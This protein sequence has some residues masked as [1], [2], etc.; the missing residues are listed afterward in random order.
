MKLLPHGTKTAALLILMLAGVTSGILGCGAGQLTATN[1]TD[2]QLSALSGRVHGGP[3]PIVGATVSLYATTSGGYGVGSTALVSALT[4]A[5][6]NFQFSG[7][8]VCPAN[9]FAYVAI[10]GGFTGSNTANPNSILL[11]ALGPCSGVNS[12]TFVWANE[13]TTIAATYALANFINV[14]GDAVNGYTVGIGAP[15]SNNG[16][17]GCYPNAYYSTCASLTGAGLKHAFNNAVGLVSNTNGVANSTMNNGALIPSQEI[18]TLGNILQACVNSNGGGTNSSGAPSAVTSSNGVS[19]DGTPCGK[20]FAFSSYTSNGTLTGTQTAAGNTVD[21][22][23]NLVKH[24]SGTVANFNSTCDS[25]SNTGSTTAASCIFNLSGAFNY[26]LPAMA[27]APPDWMLGVSYPKGSFATSTTDTFTAAGTCGS[28]AN[29]GLFYTTWVSS[30]INDNLVVLNADAST[31]ACAN[32]IAI[33]SDGTILGNSA[34]DTAMPGVVSLAVDAWG[35]AMVPLRAGNGV[36]FFQYAAGGTTDVNDYSIPQVLSV[37]SP[38]TSGTGT[39]SAYKA[40]YAQV[41]SNNRIYVPA[42]NGVNTWG[43]LAP[44]TLSHAAPVYTT[45]TLGST[46]SALSYTSI[47]L[48]NNAFTTKTANLIGTGNAGTSFTSA[49]AS[50]G[51]TAGVLSVDSNGSVW[52]VLNNGSTPGTSKTEVLKFPY[53][54]SGA[55][56]TW[57]TGATLTSPTYAYPINSNSQ[58]NNGLTFQMKAA[59]MDSSN[60]L[61]F[62]DFFGQATTAPAYGGSLRGYDTVNNYGTTQLQGCKFLAQSSYSITAWTISSSSTTFTLANSTPPAV[63]AVMN[64]SGFASSTFFNGQQVTV[65]ATT[66]G[67]GSTTGT[68]TVSATFGQSASSATEAGTATGRVATSCGS[69]TGD[70]SSVTSTPFLLYQTRGIAVDTMG[71]LWVVNGVQ[72]QLNE[73]LG[74]AAPTW[75][76]YVHNG[77]SNKP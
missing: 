7:T 28:A 73:I 40:A 38:V 36:K 39:T 62:P 13:L 55:I 65:T 37:V 57:G 17:A 67:S 14:T 11:T 22:I 42:V 64:L 2:T 66:T 52:Q 12:G 60:V 47:D 41:D 61:W 77:V 63:G 71:N 53:T 34:I 25:N 70:A 56:V 43:Y 4:D 3:N 6:G 49:A 59:V 20:L 46:T 1:A 45:Q 35:H 16:S 18:N 21:A 30:D 31:P 51:S 54:A 32:V 8:Y 10:Y 23:K 19:H 74:I 76:A 68:V 15:A 26:Y 75:P 69:N 24:P 50:G 29:N 44:S 48:N 5:N 33:G 72:G 27:T 9:Q 58:L